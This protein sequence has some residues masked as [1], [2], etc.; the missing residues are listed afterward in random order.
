VTSSIVVGCVLLAADQ[1]LGVEQ[2]AVITS[3]DL[4]NGGG[5]KVDEDGSRDIFATASLRED[6]IE[7]ARV[8]ESL[9][10]GIR[11]TVLLQAVFE[12]VPVPS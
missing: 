1:Q 3:A 7:L 11:P 4:V 6:G 10:V 2:L 9:R 8:V 12:E 5:V